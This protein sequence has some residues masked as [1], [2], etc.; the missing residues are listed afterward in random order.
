MKVNDD[1]LGSVADN[2]EE[3]ALLFLQREGS[4]FLMRREVARGMTDLNAIPDEGRDARIPSSCVR[5]RSSIG[6]TEYSQ[7]FSRHLVSGLLLR[8]TNCNLTRT[9]TQSIDVEFA[10]I[11]YGTVPVCCYGSVGQI[12]LKIMV[13]VSRL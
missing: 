5:V 2:D 11:Q 1:V 7:R 4:E 6:V 9:S 13:V 8:A 3:T 10:Q 12:I